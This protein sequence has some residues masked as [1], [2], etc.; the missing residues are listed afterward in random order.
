MFSKIKIMSKNMS[1]KTYIEG[2]SD[3]RKKQKT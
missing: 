3:L 2:Q 1:K